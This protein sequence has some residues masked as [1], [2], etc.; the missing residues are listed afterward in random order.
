MAV[1][2]RLA[3]VR[4]RYTDGRREL[5]EALVEAGAPLTVPELLRRCPLMPASTAYRNLAVLEQAAVV[6]RI[7]LGDGES[8]RYELSEVLVGHHHH[9]VCAG[10][11]QV[12][13]VE[14]SPGLER[15]IADSCREIASRAGFRLEG[16]RLDL[17]GRCERCS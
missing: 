6:R 5:I 7:Q 8:A 12:V 10:C 15:V 3:A 14:A 1:T 13:D 17:V 11:G 2:A 9:L 16:H 4:Q